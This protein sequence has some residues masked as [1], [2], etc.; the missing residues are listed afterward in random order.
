MFPLA[1][2]FFKESKFYN[3][4]GKHVSTGNHILFKV[5][6]TIG[7]ESTFP[8]ATT[9]YTKQVL[10]L[11]WKA[12]FHWQPHFIQ[13][14]FH[15]WGGKHVSTGNHILYKASFTIGLESMFPLAT[16]FFKESKFYNW[17][18]KHVS[19][20]NHILFKVSFTIGEESTFPLA[21]T[22]YTKQV[23]QLVWKACFHWQPHFI[24][25]QV[26]LFMRKACFHWQPHFIQSLFYKWWGKHVFTANHIL[27]KVSFTIDEESMFQ[28][29]TTSCRK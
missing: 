3:W 16:T 11:V 12:C 29:A 24:Q 27:Y 14:K 10:Q 20:G 13:S 25:K 1:T 9:S 6:F 7:E 4:W 2:T 22:S 15:N 26:L 23:L 8:L 5:S 17:W 18:G 21:T 28:L 19:T